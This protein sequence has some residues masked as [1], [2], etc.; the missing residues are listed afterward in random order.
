M[1]IALNNCDFRIFYSLNYLRCTPPHLKGTPRGGSIRFIYFISEHFPA[2]NVTENLPAPPFPA[3]DPEAG[4]HRT[5]IGV[6]NNL[7]QA[8]VPLKNQRKPPCPAVPRE[9]P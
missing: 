3:R 8:S 1:K 2:R 6:E 5:S 4:S 9:R 7:N